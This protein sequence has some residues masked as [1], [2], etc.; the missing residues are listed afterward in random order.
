MSKKL[1]FGAVLISAIIFITYLT[2]FDDHFWYFVQDLMVSN[3]VRNNSIWLPEFQADVTERKIP[4]VV[5]NA[6][7]MTYDHDRETLW[8]VVNKPT[9]LVEI[10]LR[11]NLLRRINLKNFKDTEAVAYVGDGYFIIT[12][13]R[14]Q[15]IT[16][17]KIDNQTSQLDKNMLQQLVLN[18]HG[19]GNKGLEGIAIDSDTNTIYTVRERDPMELIKI[20]GFIENKNRINIENYDGISVN[21]L[22]LDD[23]SGLHYDINTKHLLI[24]SDESKMLAEIDLDGN[25][26]S[27]M[28][29]EK[30]FNN[31][32][33][34]IPQ[35]EGVTLDDKGHLYIVSEP[36]FLYRFKKINAVNNITKH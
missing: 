13:E 27:Y 16:L 7:G 12:D 3:E 20:T 2:D 36:N 28:D 4:G 6:S 18:F 23:L 29:L 30:G 9:Y 19:H 5:D 22:Y 17:A 32:S 35:A 11:F 8:I 14:D 10:D 21:D 24:L 26:V 25:K 1:S 34:S 31:L 33:R 15:T